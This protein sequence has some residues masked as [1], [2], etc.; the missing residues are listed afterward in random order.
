MFGQIDSGLNRKHEGSGLG[1]PLTKG[2]IEL[3][4][5]AMTVKSKK[6][7]GTIFTLT[8]PKERIVE[9]V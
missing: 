5:G 2:L 3:H 4:G 8:L 9:P 7:R 6:G 1:L